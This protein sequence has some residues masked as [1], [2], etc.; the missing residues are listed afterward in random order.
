MVEPADLTLNKALATKQPNRIKSLKLY[1]EIILHS[2]AGVAKGTSTPFFLSNRSEIVNTTRSAVVVPISEPPKTSDPSM[3]V[4]FSA[5]FA[6]I[7]RILTVVFVIRD[8]AQRSEPS[9][10]D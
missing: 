10:H 1:D 7:I 3:K 8:A 9:H 2:D 6:V 4:K 5:R